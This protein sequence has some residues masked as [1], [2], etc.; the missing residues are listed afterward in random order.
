MTMVVMVPAGRMMMPAAMVVPAPV[1]VPA[2]MAIPVM[3]MAMPLGAAL[4]HA[5][6]GGAR[7]IRRPGRAHAGDRADLRGCRRRKGEG[8]GKS[9]SRDRKGS[10]H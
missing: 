5:K 1:A 4:H 10:F 3:A 8:C 6:T 7:L 2:A 9:R